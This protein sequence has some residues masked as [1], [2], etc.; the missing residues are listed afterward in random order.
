VPLLLGSCASAQPTGQPALALQYAP[1][2]TV[3]AAPAA[4]AAPAFGA[5][6]QEHRARAEK[7][8]REGKWAKSADEWEILALLRP[9]SVEYRKRRDEARE[10]AHVMVRSDLQAAADARRNGDL[11][12]ASASYLKAL[13]ADP[14]D[15]A[16]TD[17]LREIGREQALLLHAGSVA[18]GAGGA[19]QA[20]RRKPPDTLTAA[21]QQELESATMLLHQ[22]DYGVSAQKLQDYLRRHPQDELARRKLRDAYAG[23]GQQQL[24]QGKTDEAV[25]YL[26]KAQQVKQ[27][28]ASTTS[29]SVQSL[30]RDLAQDYYEKGVRV[31]R[32][33]L[34]QAIRLWEQ[35]LL[36]DPEH[37][38]AK[39]KLKQAKQMERNLDAI[40]GEKPKQ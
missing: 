3:V 21:E 11:R 35:A 32:N 8:A 29:G 34:T 16:A 5:F 17:A 24:D 2:G 13:A 19:K 12:G 38:Q 7:L 28:G 25:S 36:Y 39:L 1:A 27:P 10:K 6:E 40:E 30:R 31:Q 18:N 33:D 20:S 37:A 4:Q 9:D 26:Q 14:G 15:R 22:G 23:L